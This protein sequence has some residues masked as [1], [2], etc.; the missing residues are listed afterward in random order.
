MGEAYFYHLTRA[1]LDGTLPMLLGKAL[2]AGWRVAVRGTDPGRLAWLDEREFVLVTGAG[3]WAGGRVH[4]DADGAVRAV[5]QGMRWY[6][7]EGGAGA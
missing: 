1:P 7:R 4:R 2:G 3:A 6:V 5:Q